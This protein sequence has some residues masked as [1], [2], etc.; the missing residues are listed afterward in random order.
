MTS[1]PVQ[2][3]STDT[4]DLPGVFPFQRWLSAYDYFQSSKVLIVSAHSKSATNKLAQS[5]TC[6]TNMENNRVTAIT[7][8]NISDH[9]HEIRRTFES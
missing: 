3:I 1:P 8:S 6:Y 9:K 2:N 5:S 4:T 7:L